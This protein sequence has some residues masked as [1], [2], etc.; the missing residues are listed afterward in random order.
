MSR[1]TITLLTMLACRGQDANPVAADPK[2]AETGRWMFRIYCA[3]CHGIRAEGG[4]GPD[5]TRGTYAVDDLDKDLFVVIARDVNC[6]VM[7]CYT[8][9]L[10]AGAMRRLGSEICFL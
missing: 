5:L 8:D 1:L 7:Q 4:R 6:S 2:A 9:P 10:D 3:P